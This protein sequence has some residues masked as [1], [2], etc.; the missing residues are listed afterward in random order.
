METELMKSL[1]LV[2][3]HEDWLSYSTCKP[4]YINTR[5]EKDLNGFIYEF[6]ERCDSVRISE[7]ILNIEF[8]LELR[9]QGKKLFRGAKCL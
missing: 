6:R 7:I 5:K 1:E 3:E 4:S 8:Y 2:N 9:V